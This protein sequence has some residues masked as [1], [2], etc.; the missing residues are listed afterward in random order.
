MMFPFFV[1]SM[2]VL[3]TLV[4]LLVSSIQL[5]SRMGTAVFGFTGGSLIAVLYFAFNWQE[6]WFLC[7][8]AAVS[9]FLSLLLLVPVRHV[10]GG[11]MAGLDSGN[12]NIQRIDE[13]TIVFARNKLWQ[14]PPQLEQREVFYRLYPDYMEYDSQRATLGGS[15]GDLGRID[16]FPVYNIAMCNAAMIPPLLFGRPEVVK[17]AVRNANISCKAEELS[18]RVR[19]LAMHMGASLV[20]ITRLRQEW[21]YSHVGMI[22]RDNWEDWGKEIAL[23]HT[24]AIVLAVEMDR[25]MVDCAPHTQANLESI[26][27]YGLVGHIS[28]VV[29][30]FLANMGYDA[31]AHNWRDYQVMCVPIAVDA[32]LGE[33]G[34]SGLL[35]N[36]HY[37]PRLRL[38]VVTTN[39][40]LV[41]DS[42]RV[43]GIQDYC[44]RCHRCADS[45][46]V[47]AISSGEMQWHNGVLKWSM[48]AEKCYEYWGK[49][50][51]S[52]AVCMA[53]C[54]WG[55][56]SHGIPGRVLRW[57]V[58]RSALGGP[59]SRSLSRLAI[60][61]RRFVKSPLWCSAWEREV[62]SPSAKTL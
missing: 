33:L 15:L 42:P 17:P 7:G 20:G 18:H 8:F 11:Y 59:A 60:G 23:D 22:N 58:T 45:C 30:A 49:E 50:G 21:V 48:D 62:E 43:R 2:L 35:I 10:R 61:R 41:P 55:H 19:G 36:Y 5:G 52:C 1:V 53:V 6:P 16:G 31:R 9:S 39:A 25:R 27:K 47:G 46:P 12:A 37:G 40:P 32:G 29:A 3:Y 57:C 51:T 54:P 4:A 26:L 44:R 38:A 28:V 14:G 56:W 34:R 24:Y 13:R